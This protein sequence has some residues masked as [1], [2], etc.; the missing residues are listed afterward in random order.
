MYLKILCYQVSKNNQ[1]AA[2][3]SLKYQL[4]E[5]VF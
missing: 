4:G 3:S 2:L 5:G 1:Y